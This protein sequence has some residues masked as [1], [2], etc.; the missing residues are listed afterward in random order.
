MN[1]SSSLPK[2]IRICKTVDELN[3]LPRGFHIE[4]DG[5]FVRYI[6]SEDDSC[7]IVSYYMPI[8]RHNKLMELSRPGTSYVDEYHNSKEPISEDMNKI[9]ESLKPL[10]DKHRE[11]Q[12]E[13][14]KLKSLI[15]KKYQDLQQ[16]KSKICLEL[17]HRFSIDTYRCNKYRLGLDQSCLDCGFRPFPYDSNYYDDQ[18][19]DDDNDEVKKE[20]DTREARDKPFIDN[21]REAC[22]YFISY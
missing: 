3:K 15:D 16:I 4:P 6:G 21:A 14:H 18:N 7:C 17:G 19:N 1:T 9:Y 13:L 22:N 20:I 12:T 5:K 11:L 8:E 10:Q 2:S